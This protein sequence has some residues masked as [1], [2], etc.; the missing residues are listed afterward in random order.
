MNK[1]YKKKINYWDI[2]YKNTKNNFNKFKPSSFAIFIKKKY[3]D[4]SIDLLEIGC[5]NAR[6]TFFFNDKVNSIIALD[7]SAEAIDK[8]REAA[9]ANK[10]KIKFI[11]K[12][13]EKINYSQLKKINFVYSRFFLHTI[14]LR[15]ENILIKVFRNILDKNIN[16][17]F[18]I[19]FRTIKDKLKKIGKK[20]SVNERYTDHYRR[21]IN[22]SKFVRK[23]DKNNFK[24]MYFKQGLNLSKTKLENPHLCRIVFKNV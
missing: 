10:L 18:A 2:Y 8:N 6:D 9:K 23:L 20:I 14:N 3:L 13:F 24:I 16:T 5:G 4:K 19:E 12:N 17:I 21:F 15:Q 7:S 1:F 11:N 22:V